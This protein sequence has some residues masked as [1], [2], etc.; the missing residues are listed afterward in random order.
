MVLT[1]GDTQTEQ[2]I[3][4]MRTLRK[5]KQDEVIGG[6]TSGTGLDSVAQMEV[7]L[8]LRPGCDKT[9]QAGQGDPVQRPGGHHHLAQPCLTSGIS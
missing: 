7:T 3:S 4:V 5:I 8:E 6:D 1:E 9:L 2:T